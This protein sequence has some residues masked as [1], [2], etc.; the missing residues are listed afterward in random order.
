M[1]IYQRYVLPHLINCACGSGDVKKRRSKLLPGAYGRIL[2]VGFGS[3]HN[4]EFFS[5]SKVDFVWALEPSQGMRQKAASNVDK[6]S[7][8]VR[9]LVEEAEHISLKDDEVDTVVMTYTLC[10][11]PDWKAALREVR[12]VLKPGGQLLFIEHGASPDPTVLRQQQFINPV[13]KRFAGGC[14]LQRPIP[15]LI[16]SSGFSFSELDEAYGK[17]PQFAAYTYWGAAM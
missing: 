7:F 4:L 8:Q 6:T 14:N 17:G 11:I 1:G 12:R 16:R 2:D 9:W 13:W 5:A 10:T 3:G 15:D